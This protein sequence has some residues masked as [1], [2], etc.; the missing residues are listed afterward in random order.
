M[1]LNVFLPL[2]IKTISKIFGA[3]RKQ[4]YK[5]IK[6]RLTF[7]KF[8]PALLELCYM[9]QATNNFSETDIGLIKSIFTGE[10]GI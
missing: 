4:L 9:N 8:R 10:V 5:L 1:T 7:P 6:R 3:Y 2:N